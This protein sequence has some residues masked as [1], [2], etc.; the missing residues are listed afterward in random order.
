M[1]RIRTRITGWRALLAPLAAVAAMWL[2]SPAAPATQ[3][4]ARLV[5]AGN[6]GEGVDA[7]IRDVAPLLKANLPYRQ[8]RLLDRKRLALPGGGATELRGGYLL[9]CSGN[10]D[11][12]S[13][14]MERG[15]KVLIQTV[16]SL[17]GGRPAV[18]GGF[19][20]DRGGRL[21]VVIEAR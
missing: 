14:T 3:L 16:L 4:T 13:I 1:T 21:L 7:A 12:V 19:P 5:E 2:A 11:R 10:P 17:A 15:G 20:S 6:Q 8:F 9:R 18:L